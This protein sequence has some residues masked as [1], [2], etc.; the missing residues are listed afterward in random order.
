MRHTYI[1]EHHSSQN[2]SV[3]VIACF[4]ISVRDNLIIIVNIGGH[5]IRPLLNIFRNPINADTGPFC[6]SHDLTILS[7]NGLLLPCSGR[8]ILAVYSQL[9]NTRL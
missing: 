8:V 7:C 9:N 1:K 6:V 4:F 5:N 3:N 2:S